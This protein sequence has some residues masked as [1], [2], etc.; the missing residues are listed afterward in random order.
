[1]G[2][3]AQWQQWREGCDNRMLEELSRILRVAGG[4][5]IGNGVS[6]RR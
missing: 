4:G 5:R 1:M 3:F 6:I 2:A